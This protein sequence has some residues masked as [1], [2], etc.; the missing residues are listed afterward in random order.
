MF[1]LKN[2][3]KFSIS[4]KVSVQYETPGGP[5]LLASSVRNYVCTYIRGVTIFVPV[6]K[7]LPFEVIVDS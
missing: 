5:K 4:H 1:Q 2:I 6:C 7:R 3:L